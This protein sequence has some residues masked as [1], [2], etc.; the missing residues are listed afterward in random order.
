MK[1]RLCKYWPDPGDDNTGGTCYCGSEIGSAH[2]C[3]E[4][5]E[6]SCQWAEERRIK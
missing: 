5:D 6:K 1:P 4:D 2:P 3:T